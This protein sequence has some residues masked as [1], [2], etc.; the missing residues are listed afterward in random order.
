VQPIHGEGGLADASW[1]GNQSQRR[2]VVAGL[3]GKCSREC[4]QFRGT[5]G[6][7]SWR[8]WKLAQGGFRSFVVEVDTTEHDA[9]LD[10]W[11]RHV[12]GL[13]HCAEP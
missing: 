3:T 6:E 4:C 9:G 2:A 13:V 12:G 11:A 5:A 7:V 8:G 1:P 10:Y